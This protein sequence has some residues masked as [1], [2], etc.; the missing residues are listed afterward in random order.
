M[1]TELFQ[2]GQTLREISYALIQHLQEDAY[3]SIR[4]DGTISFY[5]PENGYSSFWFDDLV[6][7]ILRKVANQDMEVV[8]I[9]L[10]KEIDLFDFSLKK[11]GVGEKNN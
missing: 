2:T 3:A 7:I 4:G 1:E 9:C 6:E 10:K 11:N 5:I 8:N